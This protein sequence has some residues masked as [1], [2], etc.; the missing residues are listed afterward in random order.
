MIC[1]VVSVGLFRHVAARVV[2]G[3][4][5]LLAVAIFA[6][7]FHPVRHA[8]E[9]KPYASD[10]LVSLVLLAL[11][12]HWLRRPDRSL[13][14]WRLV[15]FVPV[16]VALSHPALF[17]VGGVSLGLAVPIWK[18]RGEWPSCWPGG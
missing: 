2:D 7:S 16:A 18:Q 17:I 1:G 12:L 3:L 9:V 14:L 8:A 15:A 6:V 11:A 4:P 5:L 10:L 13:G